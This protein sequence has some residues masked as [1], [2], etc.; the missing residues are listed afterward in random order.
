MARTTWLALLAAAALPG[1]ASAQYIGGDAP[2]P[3]PAPAAGVRETPEAAL[4]RNIRLLAGSPRNYDALV[5]AGRAALAL[6]DAQAAAGFFG[7]A[8][9]VHPTSWV[10]KAGQGAA[11]VQLLEPEP[12]LRAFAEAQRLGAT[13]GSVA[14]DRGLAFDLMG[15]QARAQSDYRAA[16]NGADPQEAR[17]RLALSLAISGQ[18]AEALATLDPLLARRDPGAIRT[19]AL[20]LALGGDAAGARIAAGAMASSMDPFFR[21]LPTLKPG[22]KAA[23]VHFGYLPGGTGGAAATDY[24]DAAGGPRGDR[25]ADI[26]Q[27]LKAAPPPAAPAA[28]QPVPI[29][30]ASAVPAQPV[31]APASAPASAPRRI[32]LQLASG[33]SATA[34]ADQFKRIKSRNGDILNGISGYVA[35]E[36]SRARLL[37]GPFKSADDARVFAEDLETARIDAFPWTSAQGQPVRKLP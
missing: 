13:Q 6:G 4:A 20:I 12:A 7:R 32:W 36:P 8:E 30:V 1:V 18:K 29:Q 3:P 14:L 26:E 22:E 33:Q 5:G 2:A 17:R 24:A 37:I 16:L 28:P 31:V 35:E 15:D 11:L 10:P 25:L 27:L 19:R 23:A 9:E 21:R 34:L